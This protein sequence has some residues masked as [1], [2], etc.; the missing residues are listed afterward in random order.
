M[1]DHAFNWLASGMPQYMGKLLER[2]GIR[3]HYIS[4]DTGILHGPRQF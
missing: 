4:I 3:V 1:T 2:D